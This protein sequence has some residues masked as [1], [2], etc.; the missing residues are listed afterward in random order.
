MKRKNL[1]LG[2][3]AALAPVLITLTLVASQSDELRTLVAREDG[4]MHGVLAIMVAV[5]TAYSAVFQ[6]WL[7]KI[8]WEPRL[9]R[10]LDKN[11][12]R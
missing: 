8:F 7:A 3:N 6:L 4:G 12:R 11:G 2:L 9:N 10:A 1:I 5:V